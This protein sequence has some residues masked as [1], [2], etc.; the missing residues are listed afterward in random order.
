VYDPLQ[1][2]D[3]IRSGR[4]WELILHI[5]VTHEHVVGFKESR[6]EPPSEQRLMDVSLH[7]LYM[8][9]RHGAESRY[10]V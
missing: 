4:V 6:N 5:S 9:S 8:P 1:L 3:V 2:D 7:D 10:R